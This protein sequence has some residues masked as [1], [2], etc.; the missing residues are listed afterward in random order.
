MAIDIGDA[1]LTLLVDQTQA[2]AQLSQLGGQVQSQMAPA[3]AAL[4]NTT[5]AANQ[6]TGSLAVGAQ[7]AVQLGEVTNL[8]GEKVRESMY[9][10]RGEAA[11]LGEMFGVHLPRHVRSFIAELPGIGIALSAAFQATAVI[12]IIEA[13]VQG[14][15]KLQAW[16]EEAHKLVLAQE[17]FG[18]AVAKSFDTLDDK[19]L[20]AQIKA[21]ELRGDHLDALR[22]EIELIDH[23]SL[24]ELEQQFEKLAKAA[25]ALFKQLE[26]SWFT[27]Q[28]GSKGA[29]SA[30]KDFQA[31]YELL[32]ATGKDKEA[33]DLLTGTK[34]SAEEVLTLMQRFQSL[35]GAPGDT[36][37]ELN[38]KNLESLQII[39]QLKQRGAGYDEKAIKA[40]EALVVTLSAQT[41]AQKE[42][43]QI[44]E[45]DISNKQE[46]EA[47]RAGAEADKVAKAQAD[48]YKKGIDEEDKA[49][50]ERR[51]RFIANMQQQEKE[52]IAL[53]QQ[54]SQERIKAIDA[55]IKEEEAHGFQDTA[56]YK[57]LQT[58]RIQAVKDA[59]KQKLAAVLQSEKDQEKASEDASK[60]EVQAV[61]DSSKEQ[62]KAIQ[63]LGKDRVLTE[64]ETSRLLLAAYEREK[65]QQ[66]VI[67]EDLLAKQQALVTK[68]QSQL[69][70]AKNNPFISPDQVRQAESLLTQL[71]NSV[72]NTEAQIVKVKT[73]ANSKELALD[74][75]Y[76][77]ES[78]RLAVA[79]G[80][81]ELAAQLRIAKAH[82]DA[83]T[84]R[85]EDTK[86]IEAQIKAL[87][88]QAHQLVV[89]G[90][91][92][93]RL[94]NLLRQ[95]GGLEKV[96]Q[97][98][99]AS[100]SKGLQNFGTVSQFVFDEFSQA[101][102]G[103]VQSAIL[104]EKSLGEAMAAAT[105]QVIS[106]IAA[107]ALIW[108]LFYTAQGIADIFWNP[109]RAGADFAAA[110]EFLAIGAAGAIAARAINPGK[111]G[112]ASS[113]GG[114]I[115]AP[116]AGSPVTVA[117]G[118]GP[119]TVNVPH[120]A[121]GGLVT[122]P[123]LAVVGE[124]GPET[125]LPHDRASL[126]SLASAI[127]AHMQGQG[128]TITIQLKTDTHQFVKELNHNVKTGR[129][130]LE[131]TNTRKVTRQS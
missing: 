79:V 104:G 105:A 49:D 93:Q 28:T 130:R 17:D 92:L 84:A 87:E 9:E 78:V 8:A 53:T 14:I 31:K 91:N 108:G 110:A 45:Q 129:V 56:Y 57:S 80:N 121:S 106:Q 48:A 67:L 62:Q 23:Q 103:A 69:A 46:E 30:L 35:K 125:V 109:A 89:A 99:L 26:T 61:S 4:D 122:R 20:R 66:L 63:D 85:K 2:N 112:S 127:A 54:G 32:L 102:I 47:Q 33:S 55:A 128:G 126:N 7:G 70:D 68:T 124:A 77:S 29:E 114:G 95:G 118:S 72:K 73:D 71:Q 65:D 98:D 96:F 115:S 58:E 76:Y 117:Q 42:I 27:F 82:L 19:L 44:K 113:S 18:T 64:Q 12:F 123:T 24:N 38:K 107:R 41:S 120:L 60:R 43:A 90:N 119:T 13:L 50:D 100:M 74:R 51:N 37:E 86:A 36:T 88:K 10:A 34:K 131:A 1:V 6:M 116:K 15:E 21:D 83:A 52:G 11:L 59:E 22:K 3:K 101:M 16:R 81:Q 94:L 97:A 75:S 111:G 39:D 5:T 40:Q 25:D